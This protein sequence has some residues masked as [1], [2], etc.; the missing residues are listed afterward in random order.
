MIL[1]LGHTGYIGSAFV[2]EIDRRKLKM[3]W[4][5]SGHESYCK[6]DI[7]AEGIRSAKPDVIINCAAYIP[8]PSVALC[9]KNPSQTIGS[10][11]LLPGRLANIAQQ[12]DI[13]FI[14]ISTGCLYDDKRV[15]SEADP[16]QRGF[17]GHCG[18]YVGAKLWAEEL[19]SE[20]HKH[21]ILRIRLPFDE[22]DSDRNYLSKLARYDQIYDHVNSLTHRGDF[23][24][25][26]LDLYEAEAAFGIY[27][28]VNDGG[29]SAA[30]IAGQLISAGI[31]SK[32]KPVEFIPGPCAGCVL[33]IDKLKS[34]GVKM[35]PIHAAIE[36]A[37]KNWR[38]A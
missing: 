23:V 5:Q 14:H 34:I 4:F 8:K 28:V 27:N 20:W 22:I 33:S 15:Y 25:A 9:N 17:G 2:R 18:M 7:L 11:I 26:A 24:K 35:R 16:P 37:I 6:R 29:E 36:D 30:V 32:D 1:L 12:L 31:R 19:V 13:P 10:N 3:T 21:Y 38:K